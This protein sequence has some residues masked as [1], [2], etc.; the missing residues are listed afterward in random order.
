[1]D[2]P[3]P[4]AQTRPERERS[5]ARRELGDGGEEIVA[6]HLQRL[7]WSILDRNFRC[8]HGEIDLIAKDGEALVFV[9]VK[10]RR[11]RAHGAPAEA[12]DARKRSR[13]LKT[14]SAYLA[15]RSAGGAEPACRFDVAE[16]R[17]DPDGRAT[18]RL[19]RSAFGA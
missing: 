8:P 1:M 7:G 14:A 11:G 13:M 2:E 15:Q 19:I 9:E 10:A 4:Q 18:V 12:V 5:S 6:V 16:V 17:M 3:D